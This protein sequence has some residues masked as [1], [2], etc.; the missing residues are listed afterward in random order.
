M[1][2]IKIFK[3]KNDIKLKSKIT[4]NNNVKLLLNGD[5]TFAAIKEALSHA[6]HRINLEYFIFSDDNYYSI[7][8]L[9]LKIE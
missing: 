8:I 2:K 6:R 1:G 7:N 5:E 3:K 9:K 4:N